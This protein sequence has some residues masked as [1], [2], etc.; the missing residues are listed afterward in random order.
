MQKS[1]R[2]RLGI[3]IVLLSVVIISVIGV[4]YVV[5]KSS[6]SKRRN[7]FLNHISLFNRLTS[8]PDSSYLNME[9]YYNRTYVLDSISE[10]LGVQIATI[11]FNRSNNSKS[12]Y[13]HTEPYFDYSGYFYNSNAV[14]LNCML[15]ETETLLLENPQLKLSVVKLNDNW[16]IY[17]KNK[18]D[19]P[20]DLLYYNNIRG[21]DERCK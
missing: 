8:L 4:L 3:L 12:I 10:I 16:I 9:E 15:Q 2:L 20:I 19:I 7:T 5:Y 18:K 14:Q 13:I 1:R 6:D 11:D 21:L 17:R